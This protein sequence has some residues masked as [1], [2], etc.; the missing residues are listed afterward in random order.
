MQIK[1]L[2]IGSR[3]QLGECLQQA[4]GRDFPEAVVVATDIDTLDATSPAAVGRLLDGGS[5]T[6]IINCAAYTAVDRAESEPQAAALLNSTIPGVLGRA[7][8]RYGCKIIHISTD[9]VFDGT[10]AA[11]LAEDA[12]T[13]PATVYGMTK[14]AGEN[15]LLDV[16]AEHSII[17]RTAWLYAATGK[18]NF[19]KTMLRLARERDSLSVVAD[20]VGSPTNADD[21]ADAIVTILKTG[22]WIPGVYHYVNTGSANWHD[23]AVET[24]RLAEI[25]TPVNAITTDL[26]PTAARRPAYS[27]LGTDR[28]RAV[29][30]EVALYPWQE[31]LERCIDKINRLN[32]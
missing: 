13:G 10:G 31:S 28:M 29:Y 15:A 16:A 18:S 3:G 19:V 23:L 6:H 22:R 7:A 14:L 27:V 5:F 20:Q 2:I 8:S 17:I 9:Y 4:L 26:Y 11:P 21:L 32:P 30:P 1:I 25:S 12:P 24:L